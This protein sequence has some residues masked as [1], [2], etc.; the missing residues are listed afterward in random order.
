MW[1]EG[2]Y[3]PFF[4]L[5]GKGFGKWGWVEAL[6]CLLGVVGWGMCGGTVG[7]CVDWVCADGCVVTPGEMW[8]W[9]AGLVVCVRWVRWGSWL[10]GVWKVRVGDIWGRAVILYMSLP[11]FFTKPVC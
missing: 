11:S 2:L 4:F 5:P 8:V 1:M 7:D 9:C 10:M 3:V 6:G